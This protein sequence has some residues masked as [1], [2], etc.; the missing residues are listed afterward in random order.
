MLPFL[1]SMCPDNVVQYFH[2]Q[3]A[4]FI[5]DHS[6]SSENVSMPRV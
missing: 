6:I 4:A 1:T 5:E 3:V 2:D